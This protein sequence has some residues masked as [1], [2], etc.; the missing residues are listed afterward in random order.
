MKKYFVRFFI[1]IN[2]LII[3]AIYYVSEIVPFDYEGYDND[4]NRLQRYDAELNESIVLTRFFIIKNYDSIVYAW[5]GIDDVM[6]KFKNTL[7]AYP[8]PHISDKYKA[9]QDIL[10][11]KSELTEQFKEVNPI[12]KN[13]IERFSS[14]MSEIIESQANTELIETCFEQAYQYQLTDK[15]NHLFR[16]ILIYTNNPTDARRTELLDLIQSIENETETLPKLDLGLIYAKQ[17]LN[18]FVKLTNITQQ[19]FLVPVYKA[20]NELTVAYNNTFDEHLQTSK[21]YQITLYLLIF[22]LLVVLRWTFRRLKTTVSELHIEVDHKIKAEKELEQINRQLEQRVADRTKE[23][24][25]KNNDLNKA[26][27]DLGDAQEQLIMQ[28][29]MASVGMLSTGIAHEIKNPLNFVNN[30]SDISID[31]VS[32]LSDELS[33]YQ[34][35]IQKDSLENINMIIQDLK[36]NC[37]K[38]KDHGVRADNIVKNMLLHSQEAGLEKEM[39]DLKVLM[40]NNLRIVFEKN[41]IDPQKSGFNIERN[42]D[43][44]LQKI[45]CAPQSIARVFVYVLDNAIYAILEKKSKI[46]PGTEFTPE[47]SISMQQKEGKVVIKIKDN[48]QG[49]PKDKQDKIFE[50]FFTTKPTGRGNTGLGLS[51]CYDT[52]VKH[53][54]GEI[55]VSSEEG[56]STEL[57]IVLPINIRQKSS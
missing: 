28:E 49:I 25:V 44:E 29:K 42:Y 43:P 1:S 14:I 55:S 2:V 3:V 51:I 35:K 47:I 11:Q 13:A 17:I 33:P 15:A 16:G 9:L 54:K 24:T 45:L 32:E 57:T 7:T 22:L 41:Q 23:L 6:S 27:A 50:P 18:H 52:V 38:I 19:I 4:I 20:L 8:N 31:L 46:P 26:L 12:L 48:G 30:F 10:Q 40:E 53:H 39:V 34:D 21:H 37:Q 36:V 5:N 56:I